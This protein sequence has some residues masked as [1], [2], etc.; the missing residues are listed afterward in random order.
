MAIQTLTCRR[1]Q[2]T[3]RREAQ[4]GKPPTKC[5][6]FNCA[7]NVSL[8]FEPVSTEDSG[9]T[10]NFGPVIGGR[11]MADRLMKMLESRGQALHQQTGRS[12]AGPRY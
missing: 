3:W 4:R 5:N 2:H 8:T 6:D 11:A 9:E 10:E 7:E 1:G 12:Y